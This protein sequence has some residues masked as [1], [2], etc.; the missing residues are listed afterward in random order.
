[1]N[2]S[3]NQSFRGYIFGRPF[4]GERVP[5]SVQN[6][7]IRNFCKTKKVNFL[8]SKSEYV[9]NQ[10]YSILNFVLENLETIDGIVFY[11]L[12][13]MPGKKEVRKKIYSKILHQ[14]KQLCFALED[15]SI[16]NESDIERVENIYNSRLILDFC[17]KTNKEI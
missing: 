11:S 10:S 13:M 2:Q 8:L 9:I 4:F 1:M 5:Q 16:V 6:L 7:V 12:F 14:N 17:L 15:I 3:F